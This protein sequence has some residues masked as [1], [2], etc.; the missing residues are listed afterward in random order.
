MV[1]FKKPT[2]A[3]HMPRLFGGPDRYTDHME[4]LAPGVTIAYKHNPAVAYPPLAAKNAISAASKRAMAIMRKANDE[5]A[6]VVI[7]RKPESAVFQNIMQV[8]FQLVAGNTAGG[9]LTDNIV[10]KPFAL[11]EITK[12]DRRWVLEK[13]RRNM[14]SLSFH[15]NT[16]VYLIDVDHAN[17]TVAAGVTSTVAGVQAQIANSDGYTRATPTPMC[18]FKNGEIHLDFAAHGNF[19]V[20]SYAAIIIHEACHKYL[21]IGIGGAEIYAD[22][23]NYYNSGLAYCIGN[24]DCYTWAAVSLYTG[25]LKMPNHASGD[26]FNA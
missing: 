14:L 20:N 6:K 24:P 11:K 16:G 1:D 17:R 7:L 5:L 3:L 10:D 12:H 22:D 13:I 2:T 19:S 26:W 4:L 8:H 9:F 15:L 23:P 25:V 18:G 21:G